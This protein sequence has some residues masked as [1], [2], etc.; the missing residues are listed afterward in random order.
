MKNETIKKMLGA[1]LVL[2][3]LVGTLVGCGN[4]VK[5][6]KESESTDKISG[7]SSISEV[8][9]SSE[10]IE[11]E[12]KLEL[13]PVTLKWYYPGK[14]LEGTPDVIEAFNEKLA[15]VL[16]NTTVEFTFVD[17]Y[18]TNWPMFLAGKEQMDIAWSGYSTPYYQDILDGNI[19]GISDLIN[20][21]APN[22]V[23]EMKIWE[24]DWASCTLDGEIYGIPC[25]Q[26]TVKEC[27]ALSYTNLLAP[28]MD[29]E[30]LL[31]E[32]DENYKLT[33][34]M[35]D[36]IEAAF[37][38][39]IDDGVLKKGDPSWNFGWSI[40]LGG[41]MGYQKLT[42][43]GQIIYIDPEAENPEPLFIWE[44]PEVR[45]CVERLA[46][47]YDMGWLTDT[48]ILNQL[49]ADSVT[50]FNFGYNWNNSWQG[51]DE[52]GV[53]E[54]TVSKQPGVFIATNRPEEA[55]VDVSSIGTASTYLVIP[56]TAENPERAIMLLNILRDEVG[57]VGNDLLNM[58]VYGFEENSE[59]AK[60]YGWCN[61][62]AVEEDGQM[63]VDK[64]ILG[65]NSSKHSMT[66]WLMGNTFKIMHDGGSLT[67]V[68]QK[69]YAMNFFTNVYPNLKHSAISGMFVDTSGFAT[70]ME[71]VMSVYNEYCEQIGFGCGGVDKVDEVFDTAIAKLN[72]AGW[73]K[74][75]AELLNQI[76]AYNAK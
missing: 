74:V 62:T 54:A 47:W 31:A 67:T 50:H 18:K 27:Q 51:C 1:T 44:I 35:L 30:A 52:R 43:N 19:M 34:K 10:S 39:A 20:E 7:E 33:E 76:E 26:P 15:E 42:K 37:Q 53:K 38:G 65:E 45:M 68:K 16:P 58:L 66:N 48:E 23:Q 46:K 6:E 55:Y 32:I 2:T 4:Q 29:Q 40:H 11:T 14:E 71:S 69:D 61:Y 5:S 9:K 13:E 63:K 75:K 3:M 21:Y 17:D 73:I 72:E 56:Y 70:E 28:Y 57:T 12:P 25:T 36:I 64:T 59:E 8:I 24:L 41:T 22:L 60:K 49:P